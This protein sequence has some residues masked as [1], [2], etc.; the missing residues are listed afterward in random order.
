M[1]SPPLGIFFVALIGGRLGRPVR[2]FKELQFNGLFFRKRP[3]L[4]VVGQKDL[5]FQALGLRALIGQKWKPAPKKW[6]RQ[7]IKM[8]RRCQLSPLFLTIGA[9]SLSSDFRAHARSASTAFGG[10]F[11]G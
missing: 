1:L 10:G 11:K 7:A 3:P 2:P 8:E 6:K 4:G 9:S 5:L